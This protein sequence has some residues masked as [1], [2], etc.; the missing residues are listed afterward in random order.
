MVKVFCW[1]VFKIEKMHTTSYIFLQSNNIPMPLTNN[2]LGS[3]L[4]SPLKIKSKVNKADAIRSGH[5][6]CSWIEWECSNNNI[7]N[8]TTTT[9]AA[10]VATKKE[11]KQ[12]RELVEF[13]R[14]LAKRSIKITSSVHLFDG[15][16][17]VKILPFTFWFL[18]KWKMFLLCWFPLKS[19]EP[20]YLN[21]FI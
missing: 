6:E 15:I 3:A 19:S 13:F 2:R 9:A 16:E 1:L 20:F 14:L 18:V 11:K 21:R 10:A 4:A 7:N 17:K 8:T 12:R 5:V